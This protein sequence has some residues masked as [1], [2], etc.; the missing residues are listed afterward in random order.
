MKL[1]NKKDLSLE[2]GYLLDKEGNIINLPALADE[3]NELVEVANLMAFL[4]KNKKDILASVVKPVVYRAVKDEP[5]QITYGTEPATPHKDK[6]MAEATAIA[7]EFLDVQSFKDVNQ[8][9]ARYSQLA[10]WFNEDY[11]VYNPEP[12][13]G[14]SVKFDG[15]ILSYGEADVI[16]VVRKMHDP[17]FVK[18]RNLVTIDFS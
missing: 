5:V 6:A 17:E 13:R 7:E 2:H 10:A 15:D 12:N 16:A 11:L 4:E 3:F 8:H 14:M 1:I 9:L 18:L